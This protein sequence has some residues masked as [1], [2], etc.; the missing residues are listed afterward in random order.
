[1]LSFCPAV[2]NLEI[3]AEEQQISQKNPTQFEFRDNFAGFPSYQGI[4]SYQGI[5]SISHSKSVLPKAPQ[6][7]V[8]AGSIA[9]APDQP[10]QHP[11]AQGYP[12]ISQSRHTAPAESE[13]S[14]KTYSRNMENTWN[15]HSVLKLKRNQHLPFP[16]RELI[17]PAPNPS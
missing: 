11:S 10:L 15:T 1:M 14:L 5:F 8:P 16:M 2:P 3:V 12:R 13:S 17:H 4:S 6:S 7:L 9:A